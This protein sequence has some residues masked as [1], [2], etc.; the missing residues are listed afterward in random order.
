MNTYIVLFISLCLIGSCLTQEKECKLFDEDELSDYDSMITECV[1]GDPTGLAQKY[2]ELAWQECY[3]KFDNAET[4]VMT[5]PGLFRC[6]A[7][8]AMKK[9]DDGEKQSDMDIMMEQYQD[10]IAEMEQ[11]M[12]IEM[13]IDDFNEDVVVES[14][15]MDQ[16]YRISQKINDCIYSV[17]PAYPIYDYMNHQKIIESI[18]ETND[19][20]FK[21]NQ[22][23]NI[24]NENIIQLAKHSKWTATMLT[25]YVTHELPHH[26]MDNCHEKSDYQC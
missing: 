5:C 9:M 25:K 23:L 19:A 26:V 14:I 2:F 13:D 17:A 6:L 18:Q 15:F 3:Y 10:M 12:I 20:I 24:L 4:Y 22:N 21:L 8:N 16:V 1:C 7:I 11:E